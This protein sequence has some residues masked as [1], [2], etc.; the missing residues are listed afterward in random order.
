MDMSAAPRRATY[1]DLLAV[2]DDLIAELLDGEL[3]T[4]PRPATSHAR[5]TTKLGM[6]LGGR[7]D[8]PPGGENAPGGWWVLEEPEMHIGPYVVVTD[9]AGLWIAR[10]LSRLD[11]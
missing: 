8:G 5:V 10:L 11:E 2:P 3:F 4:F 6:D 9:L 7:F 1:D